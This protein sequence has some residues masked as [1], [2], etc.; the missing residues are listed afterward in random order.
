M[1]TLP[2]VPRGSR[3]W[4]DHGG[5]PMTR[6]A[7]VLL[8]ELPGH[9][10]WGLVGHQ[11]AGHGGC[12]YLWTM[13]TWPPFVSVTSTMAPILSKHIER[14]VK[15]EG[16]PSCSPHCSYLP[17]HFKPPALLPSLSLVLTPS[18]HN[19]SFTSVSP[20]NIPALDVIMVDFLKVA[21]FM[22]TGW[23]LIPR[24]TTTKADAR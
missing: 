20:S 12:Q 10:T 23:F 8:P 19:P 5:L 21:F 14:V 17:I 24:S 16:V 4:F 18:Q 6:R 13:P 1:Q 9:K 2:T 11:N 3:R 22:W 15:S 7:L